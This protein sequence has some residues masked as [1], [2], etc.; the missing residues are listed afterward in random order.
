M[1]AIMAVMTFGS[2]AAWRAHEWNGYTG[3]GALVLLMLIYFAAIVLANWW[4]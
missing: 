3:S 4:A 2:F 1:I